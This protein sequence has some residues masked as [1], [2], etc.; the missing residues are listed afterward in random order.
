MKLRI[1]QAHA[2][3]QRA[4]SLASTEADKANLAYALFVLREVQRA[5]S[6]TAQASVDGTLTPELEGQA[7]RHLWVIAGALTKAPDLSVVR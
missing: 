1:E 4:Y 5:A 7:V 6:A 2:A 3:V